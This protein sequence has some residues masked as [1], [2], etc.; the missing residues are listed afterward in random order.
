M[1]TREDILP[2][3]T[4]LLLGPEA[5]YALSVSITVDGMYHEASF[6]AMLNA[7]GL[8][9]EVMKRDSAFLQQHFVS[10]SEV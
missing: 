1:K 5:A 8:V 6:N 7:A 4:T 3:N 10:A 9:H 2:T